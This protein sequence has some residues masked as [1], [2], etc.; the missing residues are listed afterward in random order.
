MLRTHDVVVADGTFRV[1]LTPKR[2]IVAA[3][4]VHESMLGPLHLA[5][6]IDRS[7][8]LEPHL[9]AYEGPHSLETAGVFDDIGHAV[10]KAAEGTFNAA[11]KVATTVA[12]PAFNVAKGA[13]TEGTHLVAHATPFLPAHLRHQMDH[14]AHVVLK[15]RLGDV[16]AK[17]FIKTIASAAKAGVHAAQHVGNALL[18]A[19][20]FVA[21]VVDVPVLLA[22][23]IPGAGGIIKGLSPLEHFQKMVTSIQKGD[24]KGLEKMVKDDISAAQGIVSLVPGIGTGVS[25]AIGAGLAALEGGKPLEIAIKAAYGAIPIPPGIRQITDVVLN[26]IIGLI[27]H[28]HDLT[29]VALHVARDRV[30]SGLPREVFDTLAQ[31]VLKHVPVQKAAGG[32][33]D[34]FVHQYAPAFGGHTLHDALHGLHMDPDALLAHAAN[35]THGVADHFADAAHGAAHHAV[36]TMHDLADHAVHAAHGIVQHPAHLLPQIAHALPAQPASAGRMLQP[37]HLLQG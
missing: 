28:P 7:A 30:P 16:N 2:R 14:A 23:Q 19:T 22:S 5:F 10:S 35:A 11:S 21:K 17:Q 34:H 20:K 15:A 29:D 3:L 27:E 37:L 25:S 4:H 9:H 13:I 24:F 12:R 1:V 33:V 32:L 31:V 36:H 26:A 8:Y 18:D 6:E